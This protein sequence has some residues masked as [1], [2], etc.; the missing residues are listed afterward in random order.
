MK[1]NIKLRI[2]K[3]MQV[4]CDMLQIEPETALQ[5]FMDDICLV[6]KGMHPND[7]RRAATFYL[8]RCGEDHDKYR[9]DQTDIMYEELHTL[10]AKYP[11]DKAAFKSFFKRWPKAWKKLRKK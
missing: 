3:Q 9:G 11:N 1:K 2:P 4:T 7:R 6:T 10:L 8:Y 5:I